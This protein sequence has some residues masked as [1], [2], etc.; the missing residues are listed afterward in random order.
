M[1]R[2]TTSWLAK[3]LNLLIPLLILAPLLWALLPG[4]LPNSADGMV[5]FTRIT[6]IVSSWRD[7]VWLPRWSLNLGFGYGIPVFIFGPPLAYWIGA[8]YNLL[9][10]SP[11]AAYK[12]M[13]VSALYIGA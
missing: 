3:A 1:S 11:E 2:T 5:H 13:L 7:G 12:A 4:G 8:A 6:E 9:G 10:F